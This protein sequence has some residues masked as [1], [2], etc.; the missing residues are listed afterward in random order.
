MKKKKEKNHAIIVLNSEK[1]TI[2]SD[3]LFK[4]FFQKFI[5]NQHVLKASLLRPNNNMATTSASKT[6][7]ANSINLTKIRAKFSNTTSSANVTTAGVVGVGSVGGAQETSSNI[8]YPTLS[9][10]PSMTIDST[11]QINR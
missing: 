8:R 3:S 7:N 5:N 1:S 6:G 10:Q 2:L 9:S 11:R 4:K